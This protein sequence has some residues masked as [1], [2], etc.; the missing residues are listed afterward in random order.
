MKI[1]VSS[2]AIL[3]GF[4]FNLKAGNGSVCSDLLPESV[5]LSLSVLLFHQYNVD[6]ILR[7]FS[8][9]FDKSSLVFV[10][11]ELWKPLGMM[12]CMMHWHS[13]TLMD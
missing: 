2:L 6:A 9:L 8:W 13:F 11:L 4:H 5:V 12:L 3:V 7:S 10:Y 1:V